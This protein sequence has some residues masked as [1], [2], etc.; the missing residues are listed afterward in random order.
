MNQV[1]TRTEKRIGLGILGGETWQETLHVLL[2]LKIKTKFRLHL[3]KFKQTEEGNLRKS[4][5]VGKNNIFQELSLFSLANLFRL[6]NSQSII[7]TA[8]LAIEDRTAVYLKCDWTRERFFYEEK[9]KI[10]GGLKK[11]QV[12][13]WN[14]ILEKKGKK[15]TFF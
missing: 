5:Y 7:E 1:H 14:V 12:P 15:K 13:W 9:E 4:G 10:K 8:I 11:I 3:Q 6:S 2:T